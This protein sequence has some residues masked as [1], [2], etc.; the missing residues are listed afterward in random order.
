VGKH[1]EERHELH[2]RHGGHGGKGRW[3][4]GRGRERMER[5]ALRLVLLDALRAGPQHGYEMIKALEERTHGQYAPSPGALYPT[6]QY[7]ADLGLIRAT[8]EGDRRVYELTEAGRAEAEARPEQV[9]AF[10]ARFAS[11]AASEASRHEVNFLQDELDDLSHTVWRGLRQAIR[12]GDAETIR[13]ARQA[14]ERCQEEIRRLIAEGTS[15]PEASE[16]PA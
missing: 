5:G 13:R 3:M 2:G 6:L 8:P 1:H 10:W 15:A 12:R 11:F 4:G 14:V 9:E 16:E 7:L